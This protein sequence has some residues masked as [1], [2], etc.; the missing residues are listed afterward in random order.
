[1]KKRTMIAKGIGIPTAG[2]IAVFYFLCAGGQ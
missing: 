2:T 1:M